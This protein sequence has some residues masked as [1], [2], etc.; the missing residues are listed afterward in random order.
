MRI[1]RAVDKDIPAMDK[2]LSEVL[3]I[4]ASIRPDI[5][6]PGTR[7]YTEEELKEILKDD[8]K[9]IFAA[10]ND[11][12]ELIGY[13]FCVLKKQPFS[14]NMIPFDSLFI[15]DLC[16]DQKARGMHVGHALLEYVKEYAK[17]IGCYEVTLNVW[18]GNDQA[19]KF[20]EH[21]GMKIKETQMEYI[22]RQDNEK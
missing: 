8:T 2:L 22:L 6:I 19:K 16:V 12:D 18:E 21:E 9:P 20:Y 14:T 13:A 11:E 17:K 10:V 7:K 3:E 1:R 15:D 5:F 4:H